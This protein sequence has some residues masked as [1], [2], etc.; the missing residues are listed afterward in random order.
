[1]QRLESIL[2]L[3]LTIIMFNPKQ[4][5]QGYERSE[6]MG[7]HKDFYCEEIYPDTPRYEGWCQLIS[8]D[9][10]EIVYNLKIKCILGPDESNSYPK[11]SDDKEENPKKENK[12]Q[13]I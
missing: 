6:E 3:A 1:M 4:I 8:R 13:R 12:P 5:P 7:P 11:R 9:E 2:G 10:E